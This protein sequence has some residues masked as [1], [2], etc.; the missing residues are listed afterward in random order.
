M[1]ARFRLP[2]TVLH[3]NNT[4]SL[5]GRVIVIEH[6]EEVTVLCL[7]RPDVV[8]VSWRDTYDMAWEK[9]SFDNAWEMIDEASKTEES[10]R[11]Q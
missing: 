7:T 5:I 11:S 6:G 2:T 8:H 1:K 3:L 4:G 10:D 9:S